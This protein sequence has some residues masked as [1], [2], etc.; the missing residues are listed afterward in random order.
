MLNIPSNA[1]T[2]VCI[3]T[4]KNG[5]LS[6]LNTI[7]AHNYILPLPRYYHCVITSLKKS[8]KTSLFEE[9]KKTL[10]L[11]NELKTISIIINVHKILKL[12]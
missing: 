11:F 12:I 10:K 1:K 4:I 7:I 8:F 6:H 3:V 2:N 5:L 9:K